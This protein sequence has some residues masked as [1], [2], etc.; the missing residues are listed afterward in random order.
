[1][2][3]KHARGF[4]SG[5]RQVLACTMAPRPGRHA[6]RRDGH[7]RWSR[8]TRTLPVDRD[9]QGYAHLQTPQEEKDGRENR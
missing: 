6:R 5:L 9:A 7:D 3:A 4:I 2:Q 1:M 8:L